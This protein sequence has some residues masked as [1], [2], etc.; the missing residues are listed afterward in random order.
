MVP[1]SSLRLPPGMMTSASP[2]ESRF[3]T[4]VTATSGREMPR[5]T[6][7]ATSIATIR[8]ATVPRMSL[9][10]ELTACAS[11]SVVSLMISMT[12]TGWPT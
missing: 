4:A 7:S 1:N 6:N 9:C 11:Y 8:I 5:P 12:A 10:C 2:P 3:M